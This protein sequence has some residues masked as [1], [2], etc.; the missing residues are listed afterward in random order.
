M[1]Q[2]LTDILS[3]AFTFFI[4]AIPS[5]F[6]SIPTYHGSGKIS[7]IFI[8]LDLFTLSSHCTFLPLCQHCDSCNFTFICL[9]YLSM[10]FLTY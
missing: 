6:V 4:H 8:K 10:V 3:L 7:L 5:I 1:Q 9:Y 2:N